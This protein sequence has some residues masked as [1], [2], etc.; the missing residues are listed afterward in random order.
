MTTTRPPSF[1]VACPHCRAG[2]PFTVDDRHRKPGR[3]YSC[4]YCGAE[5]YVK[6][7][8]ANHAGR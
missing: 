8:E 1:R 2:V 5:F 4:P 6:A 3:P 7:G